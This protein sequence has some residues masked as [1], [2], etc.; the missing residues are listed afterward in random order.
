[1]L[2]KLI[3]HELRATAK[4]FL[5]LYIAF[6]AIVLVNM[7]IGPWS[8]LAPTDNPTVWQFE[9][10]SVLQGI[11]VLIYFL[12]VV[13]IAV[14]TLVIVIQRFYRN[15]L[16]DE[17][18][19]MMTL[20]VSR[21]QHILV[22]GLVALIWNI[23]TTVLILLSVLLFV[24]T[25]GS[26]ADFSNSIAGAVAAGASVGQWILW[27]VLLLIVS[28]IAGILMLYAAMAWGPN[29]L[30]NR[31]GGSILAFII[32]YVA[33]QIVSLVILFGAGQMFDAIGILS[34]LS[35]A[36]ADGFPGF[37]VINKIVSSV[38]VTLLIAN[39]VIAVLCWFFTRYMLN[40][41]LNLA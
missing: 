15:L 9:S 38:S 3:K 2:T 20:P 19:L 31:V 10:P 40:R 14:V 6:A 12:A 18:Y 27:V 28:T 17:G 32:L 7:F 34:G 24:S 21:E 29:L 30:K 35:A 23:C 36:G 5:W 16:G 8:R 4:T 13:A 33:G 22:K 37:D 11:L 1:M 41:K 39:A 25:A 26:F